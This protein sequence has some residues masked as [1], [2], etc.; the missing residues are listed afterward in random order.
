LGR[1]TYL[2]HLERSRY[3]L[4]RECETFLGGGDVPPTN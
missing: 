1:A 4:Y 3:A 2:M